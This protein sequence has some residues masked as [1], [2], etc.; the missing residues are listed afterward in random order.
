MPVNVDNKTPRL[1]LPLPDATNFLQDDVGRLIETI[2]DLDEKVAL[3][4]A[5]GK[6][7]PTQLPDNAAKVDA[8][9]ILLENQ[10]PAKVVVV[11]N[12]GKVPLTRIPDA[13]MTGYKEASSDQSMQALNALAGDVCKRLDSGK[14]YFLSKSPPSVLDNWRELPPSAV[15]SINGQTGDITGIAKSGENSDITKLTGLQGAFALPADGA[16]PYDAVTVRQLQQVTA[17][18]GATMNGVMNNFIGAVEWFNGPR[19]QLPAGYVAADGQLASRTDAATSA[20]WAAVNSGMLASATS[21]ALWQNSQITGAEWN[22]RGMY[23]P[24]DG[25]STFRIPDLNSQ[26]ND[27]AKNWTPQGM[28]LR[29]SGRLPGNNV[30]NII[31][32][33]APSMVG[34]IDMGLPNIANFAAFGQDG[35]FQPADINTDVLGAIPTPAGTSLGFVKNKRGITFDA[36]RANPAYGRFASSEIRPNATLGI[37]IIRASGAFQAQNTN[38]RVM[39]SDAVMPPTNTQ[40]MGGEIFSSY[41][42]G[43]KEL[44]RGFMRADKVIGGQGYTRFG[45][46]SAGATDADAGPYVSFDIL[47]DNT[48]WNRGDIITGK[49]T[50]YANGLYPTGT[51][52]TQLL[53]THSIM[54]KENNK[55]FGTA[56]VSVWTDTASATRQLRWELYFNDTASP[57]SR[58]NVFTV[59]CSDLT[60]GSTVGGGGNN[61]NMV[62]TVGGSLRVAGTVTGNGAYINSS[63]CRAKDK[64]ERVTGAL[65][66]VYSWGGYT[67]DLKDVGRDVGLLAQ[68]IEKF[69]PAA[70]K[71]S[72][73]E[74]NDGTVIDDFKGLNTAGVSAAYHTEAIKDLVSLIKSAITDPQSALAII[75]ELEKPR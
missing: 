11:D 16:A 26:F 42:V 38:F 21:D 47:D 1:D 30:G 29:S 48:L 75:S 46:L 28:F 27:P 36:S 56:T 6:L 69:C 33:A 65:A 70:V 37:W 66:A 19:T 9:K 61:P 50:R 2:N 71:M 31:E 72:K 49:G 68:D 32:N 4:A 62:V 39:T 10:L 59:D 34:T 20:L 74:F 51:V 24:G 67:Y 44:Y 7:E 73:R 43:G 52:N 40:T 58:S 41:Y 13:A 3:V 14:F 60:K 23:S 12:Q 45:T 55:N 57:Q 8:N 63:D 35:V 17:G 5:D 18:Q 53:N 54:F 22:N 25:S 64:I 15:Y